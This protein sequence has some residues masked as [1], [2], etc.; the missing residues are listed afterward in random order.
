ME[1]TNDKR[2]HEIVKM[3][4]TLKEAEE[5]L[6]RIKKL[7]DGFNITASDGGMSGDIDKGFSYNAR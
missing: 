3:P 4:S 6:K 7:Q 5:M 2:D 1:D